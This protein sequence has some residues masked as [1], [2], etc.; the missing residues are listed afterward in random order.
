MTDGLNCA[1]FYV[2]DDDDGNINMS[3]KQSLKLHS[4]QASATNHR[5]NL[6]LQGFNF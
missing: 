2:D 3:C 5:Q 6:G 1:K 4:H